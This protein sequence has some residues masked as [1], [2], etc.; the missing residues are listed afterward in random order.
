MYVDKEIYPSMM[1]SLKFGLVITPSTVNFER[2]FSVL[3]LVYTKQR[4]RL[5]L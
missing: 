3:T 1:K 2:G 4:N 5:N